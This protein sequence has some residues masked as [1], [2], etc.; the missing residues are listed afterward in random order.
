M[1]EHIHLKLT[2]SHRMTTSCK[3]TLQ[4]TVGGDQE[5]TF[6]KGERKKKEIGACCSDLHHL[7]KRRRGGTE[8]VKRLGAKLAAPVFQTSRRRTRTGGDERKEKAQHDP[9]DLF[10]P[11][12]PLLGP[13]EAERLRDIDLNFG[14][15]KIYLPIFAGILDKQVEG[16][17]TIHL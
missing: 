3:A 5:S 4:R 1:S 7:S 12:R 15:C 2:A 6:V 8:T 17:M 14:I 11:H 16:S 13:V 10:L 9:Q